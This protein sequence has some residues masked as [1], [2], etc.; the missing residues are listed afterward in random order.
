MEGLKLDLDVRKT[1]V[2]RGESI[3]F[4][5]SLTNAGQAPVTLKDASPRNRTFSI[6][7]KGAWNVDAW[8]NQ[9]SIAVREGEHVDQPRTQPT[10][11]LAP[12][13]KWLIHGDVISWIGDLEPGTYS[14]QGHYLHSQAVRA[15][16]TAVEVKVADAAPVSAMPAAQNLPLVLS[17]RVTAWLHKADGGFDLFVLESSPASPPVTYANVPLATLDTAVTV[18]P[19]S[20]NVAPPTVQHMVWSLM[21]G[22]LRFLRF[23]S[24]LPPEAPLSVPLPADDLEPMA[25][26]FSDERGNL[27]VL[28]ANPD[29]DHAGLLQV[30]GKGK[31]VYHE[32]KAAPPFTGPQCALWCRDSVLALAW[33]E[34][35]SSEVFAATIPLDAP[36]KPIAGDRIFSTEESVIDLLL[37]Q[38]YDESVEGYSRV[39]FVLSHDTVND[40]FFRWKIN[41]ADRQAVPDGRFEVP[42][43]GKLRIIQSVITEDYSPLY[44]FAAPDGAVFFADSG[45]SG[46]RPVLDPNRKAVKVASSP[47]LAIPTDFSRLP[48][49]YVRFIEEGKRFA[50]A[51][52]N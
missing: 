41:L 28:L 9:M 47:S 18:F 40:I 44:L 10:A 2:I 33:C 32:I 38:C 26:P 46:F 31:P 15:E 12:G 22:E 27:H 43:A 6:H 19:S 13:E 39:L 7:V 48:T 37:A 8:G 45:F 17:P 50:Y 36:R 42:G 25:T 34:A 4:T 49:R 21:D 24:D 20:F 23:R 5:L 30:I 1:Q 51:A 3:R 16:S 11:T 14:L 35:E 29:G 52:I